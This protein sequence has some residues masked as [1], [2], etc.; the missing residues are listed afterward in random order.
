MPRAHSHHPRITMGKYY[1]E[2]DIIKYEKNGKNDVAN[3]DNYAFF[4]SCEYL[5]KYSE[6]RR[7]KLMDVIY[8]VT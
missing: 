3:P 5:M 6:I 1:N 2:Y 4:H 7:R 8:M